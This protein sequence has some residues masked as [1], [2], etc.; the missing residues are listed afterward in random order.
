MAKGYLTEKNLQSIIWK[1]V[2][3]DV[4]ERLNDVGAWKEFQEF[5]DDIIAGHIR[6][7]EMM[8]AGQYEIKDIQKEIALADAEISKFM[9]NVTVGGGVY[10][11]LTLGDLAMKEPFHM[12]HQFRI[13]YL[14]LMAF[15]KDRAVRE[16]PAKIAR[17]VKKP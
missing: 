15:Y 5:A 4:I 9:R 8:R 13:L 14:V 12:I 17:E 11:T 3:K 10:A 16:K 6:I 7:I 2:G 1:Y